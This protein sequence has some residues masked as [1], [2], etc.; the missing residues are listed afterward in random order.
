VVV[1][2]ATGLGLRRV[3]DAV[4]GAVAVLVGALRL[5]SNLPAN[6]EFSEAA[7]DF[8]EVAVVRVLEGRDAPVVVG[9]VAEEVLGA[10]ALVVADELDPVSDGGEIFSMKPT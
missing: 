2:E 6:N 3:A 9:S 1:V 8:S 5:A 4:V 10:A 7:S